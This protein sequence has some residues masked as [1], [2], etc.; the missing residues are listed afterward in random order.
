MYPEMSG[1]VLASHERFTECTG[2]DVPVPLSASVMVELCAFVAVN[3]NVAFT[4]VATRGLNVTVKE[5]LWPAAMV[6]GSDNPPTVNTE[7]LVLAPVTVT[8]APVALNVPEA[9]PLV[10]TTTLP[11]DRLVGETV[12]CPVTLA[13]EPDI[14]MLKVAFDAFEVMVMLPLVF[15]AEAGANVTVKVVLWLAAKV[16][17]AV[18][19]LSVNPVPLM[20]T[21]EIMTL[22]P[23]V[24]VTVSD[25]D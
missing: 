23:P 18:M 15:P 4:V 25:S 8:L 19:P 16:S 17:G 24:L 6:T 11:R 22:V 20:L 9:V 14:L 3:V 2:A 1:D 21:L 7:L 12:N 13:P 10:P 5:V